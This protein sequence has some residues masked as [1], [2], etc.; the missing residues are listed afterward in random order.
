MQEVEAL[1]TVQTRVVYGKHPRDPRHPIWADWRQLGYTVHLEQ[2]VQGAGVGF[3][4]ENF[5][6]DALIA[7]E[8]TYIIFIL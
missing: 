2:A 5:V 1:R 7:G 4:G 6:D 8:K 3:G